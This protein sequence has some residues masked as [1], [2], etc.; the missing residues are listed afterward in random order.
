MIKRNIFFIFWCS[1]NI[2]DWKYILSYIKIKNELILTL[3]TEW[4]AV[5][6]KKKNSK[7]KKR[8]SDS[9]R[10]NKTN[11]RDRSID[12]SS[13]FAASS[14]CRT[15]RSLQFT[16]LEASLLYL[17]GTFL[18]FIFFI[19]L[20]LFRFFD[21][22]SCFLSIHLSLYLIYMYAL[23]FQFQLGLYSFI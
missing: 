4:W 12:S 23:Q 15:R 19:S 8:G 5:K 17:S 1:K 11:I 20:R 21:F 18:R 3:D 6:K 13:T 7:H 9:E 2:K 22:V 16:R 10:H 14:N